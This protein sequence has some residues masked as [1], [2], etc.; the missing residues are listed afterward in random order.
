[1]SYD[2]MQFFDI[3]KNLTYWSFSVLFSNCLTCRVETRKNSVKKSSLSAVAKSK[4][5]KTSERRGHKHLKSEHKPS[6]RSQK[7]VSTTKPCKRKSNVEIS[8]TNAKKSKTNNKL[9][10]SD[11]VVDQNGLDSSSSSSESSSSTESAVACTSKKESNFATSKPNAEKTTTMHHKAKGFVGTK[12]ASDGGSKSYESSSFTE[13]LSDLSHKSGP[14]E[15]HRPKSATILNGVKSLESKTSK[16]H[17]NCDKSQSHKGQGKYV[18]KKFQSEVAK[19]KVK[20]ERAAN[21][22]AAKSSTALQGKKQV[23]FTASA[24]VS[25]S[26]SSS[27]DSSESEDSEAKTGKCIGQETQLSS[28]SSSLSPSP[29]PSL[30]PSLSSSSSSSSSHSSTFYPT[31]SNVDDKLNVKVDNTH[32]EKSE[33]ASKNVYPSSSTSTQSSILPSSSSN[34][35]KED[36]EATIM[37]GDTHNKVDRCSNMD[38]VLPSSVAFSSYGVMKGSSNTAWP[39]L[40]TSKSSTGWK[41]TQQQGM[42]SFCQ[43]GIK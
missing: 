22:I 25:S 39:G 18:Q 17:R 26:S 37:T 12:T 32:E 23:K 9:I 13:S 43:F 30:P 2:S 3:T 40:S 36:K 21:G 14:L 41:A 29:L 34:S 7:L 42:N 1:M 4:S 10:E 20:G 5:S 27:T 33:D 6:H 31:S 19:Q 15:K 28:S 11:L 35:S 24:K 8:K 16:Q 38:P